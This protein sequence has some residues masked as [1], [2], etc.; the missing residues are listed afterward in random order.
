LNV[1]VLLE[2][3]GWDPSELTTTPGSIRDNALANM[4]PAGSQSK[5]ATSESV[6]GT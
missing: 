4:I 2:L 5:S 6:T 1:V 3:G